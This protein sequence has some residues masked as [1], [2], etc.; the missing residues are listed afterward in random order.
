[1]NKFWLG[2]TGFMLCASTL[3][4]VFLRI[5]QV[6]PIGNVQSDAAQDPISAVF[7]FAFILGIAMVFISSEKKR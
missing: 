7:L 6:I 1:M 3:A 4:Y 2:L 5:F